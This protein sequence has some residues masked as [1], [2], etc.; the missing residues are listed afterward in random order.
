MKKSRLL[1]LLFVLAFAGIC[2][3]QYWGRRYRGGGN[4]IRTEGGEWV[5]ETKVRTAREI[6]SHSTGT[7]IWTNKPGFEKDVF[8]FVR[9]I[10]DRD[11][12][13]SWTA[14]S[15][16][17]DFPDSDLNLSFRLQQMTS[18]KVDPDGRTLRLT[19]PD[20]FNYP[21]IYT[22][23]PGGLLLRDEEV[24]ILRKYL[25]NGGVLMVDD[26]WGR[27]QWEGFAAQMKRVF[28]DRDFV[29]LP[30][31]H[32]IFH[33]VFD[34]NVPKNKLQT[35]A[36]HWAI[37]RHSTDFTWETDHRY[38]D[39][40][41]EDCRD[42]HVRALLDDKGRIMVIATHNTDNGD[43]WEREGEDDWFFHE[44]SEKRGYPLGINII[45]YLMTH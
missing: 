43:A 23:E 15:W 19:D 32:P 36:S 38:K 39:G 9:I 44:F 31:D 40:S 7:P 4:M 5:D 8:T 2:S 45:F 21:W 28:P 29:E 35:P 26:F 27:W 34:I 14:G 33:C 12:E 25:L 17:T 3:A 18:M 6:A 13:G 22:V 20:L 16:I 37:I 41:P 1:L 11:P 30:M 10:R 24:P 42:V